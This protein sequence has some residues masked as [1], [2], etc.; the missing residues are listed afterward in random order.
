MKAV[1]LTQNGPT[2]PSGRRQIAQIA[3]FIRRLS[4]PLLSAVVVIGLWEALTRYYAVPSFVLPAPSLIVVEMADNARY[5]LTQLG[6]TVLSALI[7]VTIATIIGLLAGSAVAVSS[8]AD[9]MLTPWLVVVHAVP[10]VVIAPL[11]LI[12]FG[13]GIQSE[14]FFVITFTFFPVVVATITGLKAAD[15]DVL[16][17]TRSMGATRTQTL[18]KIMLPTALPSI[19]SGIKLAISLAPVGAVIGEFVA[20]NQGLGHLLIRAVGDM[21]TG[22]AF[23][24]VVLFS[25]FGVLLWRAAEY[26][27]R[28]LLPWHASQRN[29]QL[30]G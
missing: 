27:E 29:R 19:L 10:K 15:P 5:L 12:W 9:R 1:S 20:S 21:D 11:F 7:G 2:P 18:T 13:F 30:P 26:V 25:V 8:V 3:R 17:L 24:A 4:L 28:R 16:Q 6:W 22:L 14:V 23:A